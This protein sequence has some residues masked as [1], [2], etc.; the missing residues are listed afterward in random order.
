VPDTIFA[1]SSGPLPSG[2]ALFRLSGPAAF[3][4]VRRL[5]DTRVL[6]PPRTARL[7]TLS[8]DGAALDRA[9]V[10]LFPAPRS[11]TG[12]DVA[13]LHCHGSPAVAAALAAGLARLGLRP[14]E[15]GEF[16]RRAFTPGR[17]ALTQAEAL[18]DL[19]AAETAAQL[20]QANANAAG[21]L[22]DRAEAWRQALIAE[23]AAVEAVLDFADEADVA[24][25]DPGAEGLDELRGAMAAALAAAPLA[26]RVR[27][28][29]SIAIVGPPNAGKSS[30]LNALARRD[31]AIV[32]PHAGTTRDPIEVHLDL[33]GRAAT[34]VDTAGLREARDA[35]E[36][37]G[38]A[39]ARARADAADLVLN[40][41]R[42][43][44]GQAYNLF[45]V[46]R[47]DVSGET[48]GRRGDR[49]F[50]SARTGE[51]LAALEAWLVEWA[52]DQVPPGEPPLVTTARQTHLLTETVA[53]LDA[54]LAETDA[55]LRAEQL[56]HAAQALARLT[57]RIG[58]EEVLGAIFGRFC[59]GK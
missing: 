1:L 46:N 10:L 42:E 15:P 11:F 58:P 30:L 41:G 28:G 7:A 51:G 34:L 24:D 4:T 22:R 35:I 21:R 18:A 45:I 36:A 27:H 26:E 59:I 20:A 43:P 56:R 39:R 16:T 14:A 9:L 8:L 47:I 23:M 37:E 12:E 50:L 32:S 40:L 33:G 55:L 19:L 52:R 29:L 13:E 53:A 38:I 48:P 54:A 17:I 6:P 49:L 31:V 2:V 5:T 57:G 3:D 25:A 44:A